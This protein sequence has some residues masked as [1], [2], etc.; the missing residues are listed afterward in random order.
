MAPWC[1]VI[2]SLTRDGYYYK[3]M[4]V[5][6]LSLKTDILHGTLFTADNSHHLEIAC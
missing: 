3:E 4:I 5:F 1:D 6:Q 2:V